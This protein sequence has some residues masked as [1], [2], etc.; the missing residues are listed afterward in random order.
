M[1]SDTGVS[2]P[3]R[4]VVVGNGMAGF[5]F[6]Q[7][8]AG[9]PGRFAVTVAGEEPGGA[10]NR[11]KLTEVLAGTAGLASV[12]LAGAGWYA[13]RGVTLLAG[14]RA[15][16]VD[17]G[18]RL[19]QLAGGGAVPYDVLVLAT[20]SSAVIPPGVAGG[21]GRLM[22]GTAPFHNL[23]DC[24]GIGALAARAGQAVVLGGGVL[25]LEAARALALR[26]L[27]VTLVQRG[28][29]LMERQLDA[30]ASRAVGRAA[31]AAGV[32]VAAGATVAAV[33]GGG[34]VAAV[35]LGDGRVLGA[36]L[37]VLACGTRPR[38]ELARAAGLAAGAGIIVDDQMRSVTDPA[39]F[40]IGECAEHRGRACGLIAPSW[41]QARV[42][43]RV[44]AGGAE[45]YEAP[46]DVVRLKADGIELAVLG[47]TGGAGAE[48]VRFTDA[49]RGVYQKLV[50][51]RGSLAGAILAGDTRAAGLLT[52]LLDRGTALPP[53]R[54]ALL[55]GR[56]GPAPAS[57]AALPG[58]ATVC[59]CNG[60]TKDAICAAWQG[61]ARA[62]GEIAERTRATTG[63]GTCRDA[64]AELA[65][66]LAGAGRA[67]AGLVTA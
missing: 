37:L 57:P 19:V 13:A 56:G 54:A 27:P 32:A 10:Y 7:E 43:A 28:R 21:G 5:R 20:G 34:R 12:G 40:A 31:R 51:R 25:G 66:W 65:A 67:G 17:R 60:V 50:L 4:V 59:Q 8:L 42:A 61:G 3:V 39:V 49:A 11:A 14:T 18:R 2:A 41:E 36:D 64:V 55:L 44:I 30:A 35:E 1:V 6:V 47:P 52:Q 26:G 38:A 63:C 22:P 24:A 33:R 53:D 9:L 48:V 45:R 58:Q 62:A 46:P 15:A 16:A 23:A 29:R